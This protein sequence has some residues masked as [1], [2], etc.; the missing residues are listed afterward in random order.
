VAFRVRRQA[1]S[2]LD[3]GPQF[4]RQEVHFREETVARIEAETELVDFGVLGSS[5]KSSSICATTMS[6][7]SR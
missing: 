3:A 2:E 7:P 6:S 1:K 4:V 5:A